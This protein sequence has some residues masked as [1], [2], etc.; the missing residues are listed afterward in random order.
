MGL[1][2]TGGH[3]EHSIANEA[4]LL[5]MILVADELDGKLVWLAD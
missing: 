1:L 2:P 4:H 5:L 3:E